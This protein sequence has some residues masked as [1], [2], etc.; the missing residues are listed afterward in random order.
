MRTDPIETFLHDLASR[1]PAPGGG[2]TAALHAAQG[3]ALLAMVARYSDGAKYA[4][5]ATEITEVRDDAD[6]LRAEALGLAEQDAAAFGAVGA[7]YA[8]PKGTEREQSDRS[9]AIADALA[10]AG[11]VPAL[12]VEVAARVVGLAERLRPIGNPNVVTDVAAAADAARAA[13]STSRV[14]VEV[15]LPGITDPALRDE[16]RAAADRTD[17]L[18]HRAD[19]I[20][21]AVREQIQR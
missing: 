20:T 11:Q 9:R 1:R 18:L 19:Q 21:T 15:N 13:L 5:H 8:L 10:G 2:A 16:L 14:H 4:A 12:V 6:G 7:A 3:A 17:D